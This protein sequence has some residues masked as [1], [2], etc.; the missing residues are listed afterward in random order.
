MRRRP[1]DG[2]ANGSSSSS[3][4]SSTS[5]PPYGGYGYSAGASYGGGAYY[6]AGAPQPP[7]QVG[8]MVGLGWAGRDG[9][10]QHTHTNGRA[11][12]TTNS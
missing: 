12:G 6:G 11:H 8:Y 1:E 9:K 7:R 2:M 3:S 5:R 4:S 10:M